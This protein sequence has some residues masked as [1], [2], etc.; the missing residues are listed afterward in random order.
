[1]EEISV[2]RRER[3]MRAGIQRTAHSC[4]EP[5]V[6]VVGARLLAQIFS[7][8]PKVGKNLLAADKSLN[9]GMVSERVLLLHL[10]IL[11]LSLIRNIQC[12]QGA[13]SVAL[14]PKQGQW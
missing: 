5:G 11:L 2:I 1:M 4:I 10:L 8:F 12:Q 13:R 6:G 7:F 3:R 9:G 14:F